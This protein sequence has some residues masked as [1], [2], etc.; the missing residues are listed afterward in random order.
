[1]S[2]NSING[3]FYN[4]TGTFPE[5]KQQFD[6]QFAMPFLPSSLQNSIFDEV[7]F[8]KKSTDAE[9]FNKANN[10]H[11]IQASSDI[12]ENNRVRIIAHRGYTEN[13]PENTIPAF[14]AAAENGYNTIECDVEWTKDGIPVILHDSTINRTARRQNGWRLFFPK[15]CSDLTYEQLTKYDFGSWHSKDFKGTKIPKFTEL[16][17][18]ADDYNLDLYVELKE[19]TDFDDKKAQALVQ[20][21]KNA[22]L[23]DKVTWI[24]F[25]DDYLKT[26]AQAA[27]EAR[28]GYLSKKN[29][30]E[31]TINTLEN[32]QTGKN[33]V[34]LDLKANKISETSSKTLKDAGF[35]F[36]AW[37]VDNSNMLD[38]LISYDC[39]GITTDKITEDD[40][41]DYYNH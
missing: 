32:L 22:G 1:M 25:N 3:K 12:Q 10:S 24:S 30:D 26:M 40:I 11:N 31:N 37:T 17:D 35:T 8:S 28:L 38:N 4:N 9:K 18:C 36:E 20:A 21:V 33:E 5:L 13:A 16:L 7:I 34:F 14:I 23:E 39:K 41:E 6:K 15:K 27:P 2:I 19:T 29:V